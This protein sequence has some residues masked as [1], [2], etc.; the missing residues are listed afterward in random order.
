MDRKAKRGD[1]IVRSAAASDDT[2]ELPR[3]MTELQA[4][5][6]DVATEPLPETLQQLL[7]RLQ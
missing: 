6:D 1:R 7:D 4:A 5:F 3:L 2:P